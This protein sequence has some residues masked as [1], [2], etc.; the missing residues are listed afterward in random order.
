MD[1]RHGN[2][3][4]DGHWYKIIYVFVYALWLSLFSSVQFV[5]SCISPNCSNSVDS[6]APIVWHCVGIANE[7]TIPDQCSRPDMDPEQTW[8][9]ADIGHMGQPF[10][11]ENNRSHI[12][13][14]YKHW[15]A[16]VYWGV[17][18]ISLTIVVIYQLTKYLKDIQWSKHI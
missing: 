10:L 7:Y 9:K 12:W 15:F 6:M 4:E 3:G 1:G 8:T 2:L 5:H 18:I 13:I 14:S 11:Q 17:Y 16:W